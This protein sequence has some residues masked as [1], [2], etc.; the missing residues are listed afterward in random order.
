VNV[1]NDPGF[2]PRYSCG[3]LLTDLSGERSQKSMKTISKDDAILLLKKIITEREKLPKDLSS[4]NEQI[5]PWKSWLRTTA[6][7]VE[8]IFGTGSSQTEEVLGIVKIVGNKNWASDRFRSSEELIYLLQSMIIEVTELWEDDAL[9][10][11]PKRVGTDEKQEP[12]SVLTPDQEVGRKVF[13]VHG[14]DH[15]R[16]QTVARFLERLKLSVII[17]H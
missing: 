12:F 4:T 11:T 15:G 6:V 3:G 10:S 5:L 9:L 2:A 8:R 7:R 13:I 16:L 14:H 17:L 1:L